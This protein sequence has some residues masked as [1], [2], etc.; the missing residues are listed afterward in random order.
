MAR[1][2]PSAHPVQQLREAV[3]SLE[4]SVQLC[5]T[6]PGTVAVHRLRTSTRRAE[7][8]FELL[9][10]LPELPPC[11]RQTRKAVRLLKQLRQAAGRLRDIDVQRDLVRSEVAA[12]KGSPLPDHKLRSEAR[13]LLS[14]LKRKAEKAEDHLLRLL[15]KQQARLTLVFEELLKA[16][17]PA[18]SI[19][20]SESELIALTRACYRNRHVSQPSAAA[21]P[22]TTE[23]LHEIRKRAKLAR[24]LAESAPQSFLKAH[25]LAA[26]FTVLQQAGGLWHDW[27]ILAEFATV[28][29]G[30]SAQLSLRFAAHADAT[31]RAFQCR[32]RYKI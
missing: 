10:M 31:R 18:Q 23:E 29:L 32:L 11:Q 4:A 22:E 24:Y 21:H 19:A 5:L 14:P 30:A 25:R 8:Q 3:A 6:K 1:S 12:H 9:S 20:L 17:A 26:R 15:H 27:L 16:L 13:H 28:E 2:N 7:A